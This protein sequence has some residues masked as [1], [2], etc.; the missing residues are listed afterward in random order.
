MDYAQALNR[1]S[2]LIKTAADYAS[3]DA[4]WVNTVTQAQRDA[5]A[6]AYENIIDIIGMENIKLF[7][8]MWEASG[9]TLR[10]LLRRDL[11][12]TVSGATLAQAGLGQYA[13]S[14]DG[15][16]DVITQ[17]PI[18]DAYHR[19][20]SDAYSQD[21][22]APGSILVQKLKVFA[23]KVGFV[24]LRL[25]KLGSPNGNLQAEI[26][27]AKDGAAI[28]NGTSVARVCTDINSGWNG[29][30][31]TTP[32]SLDKGTVYYLALL[33]NGNT[34]ASGS[35]F[36][37]SKY[38]QTGA[39]GQGRHVYNGSTWS[40]TAGQDYPFEIYS[41]D[42]V[43]D[44]D[45]SW[46][47]AHKNGSSAVASRYLLHTAGANVADALVYGFS[48]SGRINCGASESGGLKNAVRNAWPLTWE[49]AIGTF[50][51]AKATAKVNHYANGRLINTADGTA[52]TGPVRWAHPLIIGCY[53][54]TLGALSTYWNGLV[55]PL[56]LPNSELTPAQVGAVTN[57]LFALRR[58][59]E[60][61]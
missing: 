58:L 50:S 41:D 19:T 3:A 61:V 59:Q 27:T 54:S 53:I 26:R 39:Y 13:S 23:G 34:N 37:T 15:V 6:R 56:I 55:G 9:T 43:F 47:A 38:D 60:A 46:I 42:L 20:Y 24:R 14:L 44:T 25:A 31:F 4:K 16:N 33:Y 32:P 2:N 52:N 45:L 21:M 17:D 22:A 18:P 1:D 10:D 49:V 7:L 35:D 29:F 12:F 5:V 30:T 8:P 36:I 51:K 11:T 48:S 40:D 28:A 57:Q